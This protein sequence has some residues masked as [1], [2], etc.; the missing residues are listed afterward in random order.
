M[1]KGQIS[2]YSPALDLMHF[3]HSEMRSQVACDRPLSS[4]QS[5]FQP[6][7]CSTGGEG[8]G[9]NLGQNQY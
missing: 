4:P 1:N 6:R 5:T 3:K 2:R 8:N 9:V 7:R